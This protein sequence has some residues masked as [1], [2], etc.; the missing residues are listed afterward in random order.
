MFCYFT[1]DVLLQQKA[2]NPDRFLNRGCSLLKEVN[3]QKKLAVKLPKVVIILV[4]LV[5]LYICRSLC[6]CLCVF[7]SVCLL[8]CLYL[9][10]ISPILMQNCISVIAILN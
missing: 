4:S 9:I 8:A 7:L 10:Y 5:A 6:I 3:A 2:K 1:S